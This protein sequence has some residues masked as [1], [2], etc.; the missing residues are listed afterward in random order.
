MVCLKM[1]IYCLPNMKSFIAVKN[2]Y[3]MKVQ[4]TPVLSPSETVNQEY[5]GQVRMFWATMANSEHQILSR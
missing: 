1:V 3:Y 4:H 2:K 5:S